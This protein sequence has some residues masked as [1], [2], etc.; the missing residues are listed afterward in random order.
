[1][2]FVAFPLLEKVAAATMMDDA[3]PDESASGCCSLMPTAVDM[4]TIPLSLALSGILVAMLLLTS[5][6]S[7]VPSQQ[8]SMR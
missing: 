2:P 6:T 5:S 4:A 3:T 8:W 7:C 1:M